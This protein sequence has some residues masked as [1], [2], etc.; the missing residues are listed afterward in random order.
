MNWTQQTRRDRVKYEEVRSRVSTDKLREDFETNRQEWFDI[1]STKA[2]ILVE[3]M[4]DGSSEGQLR[5][6]RQDK[7]KSKIYLILQ[8]E[9]NKYSKYQFILQC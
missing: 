9:I 7:N 5:M 6:E 2:E 1:P 4:I 8:K 3:N